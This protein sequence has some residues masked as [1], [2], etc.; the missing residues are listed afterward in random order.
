MFNVKDSPELPLIIEGIQVI[1][2][3]VDPVAVKLPFTRN[4]DRIT[5]PIPDD[6]AEGSTA[7][8]HLSY[9][10]TLGKAQAGYYKSS[11]ELNG[12]TTSEISLRLI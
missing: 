8:M 3:S 2:H 5:V 6:L 9:K 10:C 12:K 1:R 11:V 7:T 4:G